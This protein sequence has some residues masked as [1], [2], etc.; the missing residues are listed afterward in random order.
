MGD[1]L[2]IE[3]DNLLFTRLFKN[4]RWFNES[5]RKEKE[6]RFSLFIKC[7]TG[8]SLSITEKLEI[9]YACYTNSTFKSNW[10]YLLKMDFLQRPRFGKVT[11]IWGWKEPNTLMYMEELA[12]FIPNFKYIHVIRH[13]LDMAFSENKQQ[14]KNWGY[15]FGV[16]L[17][18]HSDKNDLARKQL[19]YWISSNKYVVNIGEKMDKKFCLVNYQTLCEYPEVE[20]KKILNFLDIKVSDEL[21]NTLI[22]I[23][24]ND[25]RNCRYLDED[26]TIFNPEQIREV[27][28]LGFE[29]KGYSFANFSR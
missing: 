2:N 4:P 17:I 15:K 8:E 3:R 5:S 9:I 14:L 7:M 6:R 24:K 23:P 29:V 26:I 21:M 12:N 27:K 11:N 20:I 1:D 22:S 16:H 28:N 18:E 10:R 13:G 25:S 19:D